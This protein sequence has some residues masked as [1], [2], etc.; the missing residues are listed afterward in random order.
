M[1]AARK[2]GRGRLSRV[3]Q[4][5]SSD[6]LRTR[7]VLH[8]GYD[9]PSGYGGRCHA[10]ARQPGSRLERLAQFRR[11]SARRNPTSSLLSGNLL[12]Q[13]NHPTGLGRGGHHPYDASGCRITFIRACYDRWRRPE[14]SDRTVLSPLFSCWP[15]RH[16]SC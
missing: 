3:V 12:G 7:A 2:V 11:V 13:P 14:H 15:R 8:A 1:R 5:A 6:R 10:R 4:N 9:F 16:P